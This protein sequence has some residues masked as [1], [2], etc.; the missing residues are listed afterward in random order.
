MDAQQFK[1]AILDPE[2]P[3]DSVANFIKSVQRETEEMYARKDAGDPSAKGK[4][5]G[6]VTE[7]KLAEFLRQHHRQE[8]RTG[9]RLG[10]SQRLASTAILGYNPSWMLAQ[11]V[12]EFAQALA[13]VGPINMLRGLY[14]Y[15]KM[16]KK[17]Q[18]DLDSILSTPGLGHTRDVGIAYTSVGPATSKLGQAM[19]RSSTGNIVHALASGRAVRGVDAK[20]AL[21][22]RRAAATAK[23]TKEFD[24]MR[25]GLG[26]IMKH[27]KALK[28]KTRAQAMAWYAKHPEK[29]KELDNY[30]SDVMGNWDALTDFERSL[31]HYVTFYPF[32]RM[33]VAWTLSTFPKAHPLRAAALHFLAQQNAEKLEQTVGSPSFFT[34]WASAPLY[35][36][37]GE[38]LG[39]PSSLIPLHRMAPGSNTLV[40]ALGG[41]ASPRDFL[42]AVNP[43]LGMLASGVGGYDQMTGRNLL[44]QYAKVSVT[45]MA[46]NLAGQGLNMVGVLRIA[47]E[48]VGKDTIKKVGGR[49]VTGT[50]ELFDILAGDKILRSIVPFVPNKTSKER[51][52]AEIGRLLSRKF[53]K[54]DWAS[55]VQP[56]LQDLQK[57]GITDLRNTKAEENI[58]RYLDALVAENQLEK[59]YKKY[60]IPP[61]KGLKAQYDAAS[62]AASDIVLGK[63]WNESMEKAIEAGLPRRRLR[64]ERRARSRRLMANS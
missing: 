12:A 4:V 20:K 19:K 48:I 44:P 64:R 36:G 56:A 57:R 51:Q 33:S 54:P 9:K 23:M 11:P 61:P 28:G 52:K 59:V 16:D 8:G 30:M 10:Q 13:A 46:K 27:E 3:K 45:D 41:D 60:G 22:I 6:F 15:R 18:Q 31:S 53:D 2:V 49:P 63:T 5:G 21:M 35:S 47:N 62:G 34:G 26:G 38:N 24:K 43:F 25:F 39:E 37:R 58:L 29:R 17:A 7:G 14:N 40:E 50:Q 55:E 1:A 32:V 42:R